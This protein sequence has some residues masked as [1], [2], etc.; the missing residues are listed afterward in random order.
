MVHNF[1]KVR[2]NTTS[3]FLKPSFDNKLSTEAEIGESDLY[4]K[5]G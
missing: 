4:G 5:D 3:G 2:S 1:T